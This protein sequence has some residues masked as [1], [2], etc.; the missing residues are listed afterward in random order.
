MDAP[1]CEIGR[2]EERRNQNSIYENAVNFQ[3]TLVDR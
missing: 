1:D 3:L 2:E